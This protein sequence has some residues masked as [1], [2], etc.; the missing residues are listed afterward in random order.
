MRETPLYAELRKGMRSASDEDFLRDL[1]RFVSSF[2]DHDQECPATDAN[3][4]EAE[5]AVC[6]CGFARWYD[7]LDELE[8]RWS[9]SGS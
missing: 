8:R 1:V 2:A 4:R 6:R 5:L 3:G 9:Q 7:F